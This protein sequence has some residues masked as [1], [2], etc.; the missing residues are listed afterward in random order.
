[1]KKY[2][3][4][5]LLLIAVI[6]V[7]ITFRLYY[8]PEQ[9]IAFGENTP[10]TQAENAQDTSMP[11][12]SVDGA[13]V[14]IGDTTVSTL[15]D[16]GFSLK[17]TKDGHTY[18][19]SQQDKIAEANNRYAVQLYKGESCVADLSYTNRTTEKQTVGACVID[20]LFFDTGRAGYPAAKI[21]ANGAEVSAMSIEDIPSAFGGFTKTSAVYPEYRKTVITSEA[22]IIAYFS[23]QGADKKTITSFGIKNYLSSSGTE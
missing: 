6:M 17:F 23:A 21:L 19:I 2:G 16:A 8:L 14:K 1:M 22:T 11:V 13:E 3:W 7:I 10:E 18:D 5:I 20:E 15:L 4:I 12:F 9:E